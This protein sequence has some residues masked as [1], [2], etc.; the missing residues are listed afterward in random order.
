VQCERFISVRVGSMS[1]SFTGNGFTWLCSESTTLRISAMPY[2]PTT[3]ATSAM[4]AVRSIKPKVN[5]FWAVTASWPTVLSM[6]PSAMGSRPAAIV[7]PEMR[8]SS[9]RPPAVMAKNSAGPNRMPNFA[10]CGANSITPTTASTPPTNEPMATMK[11]TAP[12]RP[13]FV[14][15]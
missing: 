6:S 13:F 2:R 14:S 9:S 11:S 1:R 15:W 12:A 3:K 4:P 8:V 10:S 5:R 7:P